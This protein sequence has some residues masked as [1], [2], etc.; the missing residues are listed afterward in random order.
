[1]A[2][3]TLY[4]LAQSGNS[5]K[6]ALLLELAGAKWAPRFVDMFNGVSHRAPTP[7]LHPSR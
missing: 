3:Y 6:V 7:A 2:D 4:C 5:Y 1:M